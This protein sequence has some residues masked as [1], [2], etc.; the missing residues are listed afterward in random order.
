MLLIQNTILIM[1]PAS[2]KRLHFQRNNQMR[3]KQRHGGLS[4]H[5][6]RKYLKTL[7][8]PN[9]PQTTMTSALFAWIDIIM[10]RRRR[11][12]RQPPSNGWPCGPHGQGAAC[13][14]GGDEAQACW[15]YL[16]LEPAAALRGVGDHCDP[17]KR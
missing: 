11:K 15:A 12:R 14:A 16:G 7:Y 6:V 17:V 8:D 2:G 9:V 3:K 10:G 4:P 5:Y 1:P 13:G